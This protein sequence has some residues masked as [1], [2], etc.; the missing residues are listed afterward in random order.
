MAQGSGLFVLTNLMRP[1]FV[2]PTQ[3]VDLRIV[4][5]PSGETTPCKVTLVSLHRHVRSLPFREGGGVGG[6]DVVGDDALARGPREPHPPVHRRFLPQGSLVSRAA[7]PTPPP[8]SRAAG[9]GGRDGAH[10]AE[11][12]KLRLLER[13]PHLLAGV[14][15]TR[16]T[17]P[18]LI[19]AA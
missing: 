17:P 18:A 19:S 5:H 14:T 15:T 12:R 8:V 2:Q 3:H 13:L 10:P 11:V 16:A 7:G 1:G 9:G 6:V 4:C